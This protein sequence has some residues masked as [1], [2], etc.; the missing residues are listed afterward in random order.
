MYYLQWLRAG[1]VLHPLGA[2]AWLVFCARA[3]QWFL[4]LSVL[5]FLVGLL[6]FLWLEY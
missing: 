2:V 5:E 6:L 1:G 4:A 3:I